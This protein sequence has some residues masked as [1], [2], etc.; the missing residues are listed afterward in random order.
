ML[1]LSF[2]FNALRGISVCGMLPWFTHIVPESRRGEF[3]ARDQFSVAMAQIASLFLFSILLSGER[4]WY[5][6]GIIFSISFISALISLNFLRRVPD[7]PVEKIVPNA[8]PLPWKEMLFYPPFF[9]YLR[10]IIVINMAFGASNVFWVRFFRTLLHASDTLTLINNA[11]TIVVLATVLFLVAPMI[12]RSGNKPVLMLSGS[13]FVVHFLGWAAVAAG[14]LPFNWITICWQALTSGFG[15]ALW[16]LANTRAVMSIVPVMGRPH[17]LALYSVA[18]NVTVGVVPLFWG[19]VVDYLGKWSAPWGWWTWNSYSL[20]YC[21]LSFTIMVGLC[22]LRTI[23]EPHKMTWD[24]FMRELLVKTPSRAIS[25]VVSRL[26]GPG[27]G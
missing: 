20:L 22:V 10:Y 16:N 17:F 23:E 9:K 21:T 14:L 15:G 13:F 26:R 24:V 4:A 11:V 27:V 6:F 2:G 7:V 19:P 25:R 1:A 18:A 3:L 8:T 12:D 5:S